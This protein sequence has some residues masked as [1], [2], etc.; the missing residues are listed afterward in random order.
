MVM[1]ATVSLEMGCVSVLRI[2]E[3]VTSKKRKS[4]SARAY[5]HSSDQPCHPSAPPVRAHA[6]QRTATAPARARAA[7]R[8]RR[9]AAARGG[10]ARGWRARGQ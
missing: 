1:A 9:C 5:P 6:G 4:M 3:S 10:G 8:G 7:R 2:G